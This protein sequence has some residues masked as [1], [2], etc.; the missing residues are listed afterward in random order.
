MLRQGQ[1][2]AL[3][4]PCIPQLR[5]HRHC[6]P[7]FRATRSLV[8]CASSVAAAAAEASV[9]APAVA[10]RVLTAPKD[11]RFN[12]DCTVFIEEFR[13][14]GNEAGPDQRANIITIANLLQVWNSSS[15]ELDRWHIQRT[16]LHAGSVITTCLN[17]SFRLLCA[18]G[19][20]QSRRSH[21]GSRQQ[22]LCCN[23]WHGSP[24]LRGYAH[25]DTHGIISHVVSLIRLIRQANSRAAALAQRQ[26]LAWNVTACAV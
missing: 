26:C 7:K 15:A 8:P 4:A 10:H 13:I 12:G 11:A 19:R 17:T 3:S 24:D 14:R 5:L 23:A 21:V 20:W 18:G 9:A 16:L 22:W 2:A 25:A 1:S 6:C